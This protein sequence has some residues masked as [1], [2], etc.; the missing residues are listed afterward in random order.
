MIRF[1]IAAL[2]IVGVAQSSFAQTKLDPDVNLPYRWRIAIDLPRHPIFSQS[3]VE[4]LCRQIAATLQTQLGTSGAVE[5]FELSD[6]PEP[7]LPIWAAL[8]DRGFAALEPDA[9]REITPVKLHFLKIDYDSGTGIFNMTARQL[10]GFTGLA[11][12]LARRQS[13]RSLETLARYAAL[14][15]EPDFGAVG[16][17]DIVPGDADSVFITLRGHAVSPVEGWVKV[18][19]VFA[20]SAIRE[21]T[22]PTK[23]T[24]GK[25]I[26]R[27]ATGPR[28]RTGVPIPSTYLKVTESVNNGVCK[29][30][31]LTRWRDPFGRDVLGRDARRRIGVRAMKLATIEQPVR[32]KLVAADGSPHTRGSLF[33]VAATDRDFRTIPAA[34]DTFD[35]RK[36]IYQSPRTLR[37]VACVTV[38]LG[39][40]RPQQFPVP[41]LST[42]PVVLKFELKPEDEE[43]AIFQRECNDL[44]GRV[45]E[46]STEQVALFSAMNLLLD[47]SK[48][49]DALS[50]AK[51]G[52][53]RIELSSKALEE[54]LKQVRERAT[55]APAASDESTK[56]VLDA[57]EKQL[58]AIAAGQTK[59]LNTLTLLETGVKASGSPE[60]LEKEFRAKELAERIKDHIAKGDIP[61]ALDA[62]DQLISTVPDQQ[63][64]KDAREKLLAEWTPKDE[65][66]RKSRE[67]LK[68]WQQAKTAAEFRDGIN[69]MKKAIEVFKAKKDRLGLRKF[70]NTMEPAYAALSLLVN[71]VDGTTEEGPKQLV[72]LENIVNDT[73]V[74][75]S[76]AKV[77][78]KEL[79]PDPKK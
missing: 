10:D 12:P 6:P 24:P 79:Q 32:V 3:V 23:P 30:A 5:V 59:L 55:A 21:T 46:L 51:D 61:D 69:Q 13:V 44:R 18:G 63:D 11:S 57:C 49:R 26:D 78:L 65:E 62:Y 1:F 15:I 8:R 17:V 58:L 47:Q 31:I 34:D 20:V 4:R 68:L 19:D 77:F 41:V 2:M 38:S 53:G 27:F 64:L 33:K 75:E 56:A 76:N 67:M 39:E 74:V 14:M 35:L 16:T 60:R 52:R 66:H 45:A 42:D 71:A 70:L 7:E 73:R 37:N 48:N 72:A 50:R 22:L 25:P 9:S 36:G 54:E 28:I 29:C 43:K 40:G